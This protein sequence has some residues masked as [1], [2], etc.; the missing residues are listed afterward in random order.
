ME[1]TQYLRWEMQLQLYLGWVKKNDSIT[2]VFYLILLFLANK[3]PG[4][5]QYNI[6]N[7]INGSGYNYVSKFKSSTA[8]SLYGRPKDPISKIQGKI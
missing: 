2:H 8:K 1:S 4:P 5:D 3:N 7:L 6:N